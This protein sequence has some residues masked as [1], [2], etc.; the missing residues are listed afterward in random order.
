MNKPS[1]EPEDASIFEL[2]VSDDELLSYI[3]KPYHDSE[4][5][6]EKEFNLESV[7][8]KNMNLWLPEHWKNKD[9]YDYQEENLYQD[10]K[11]FTSVETIISVVNARI[12]TTDVMP[13]QDSDVSKQLAKDLSKTLF[14]HADK[15]RTI[16]LFRIAVRNLLIKR[17]GFVK[18]RYDAAIDDIVPEAIAPE[19]IIVDK[20]AVWGSVPRFIAQKIKNKTGEE[21]LSMFPGKEQ[22]IYEMF[23]VKRRD[24]KGN[25]VAYKAQMAKKKDILEVWFTYQEEGK[26]VSAVVFCDEDFRY[27]LDKMRNPN[28]NYEE[29]ENSLSNFL[30]YPMPPFIPVNYLNDGSSYIDLTSMVEQAAPLQM[31][32]DRRGFQ[33][34]E[35]ADQA[36]SG[37]VFNTQMIDKSDIA[38]LTGSPDERIGVMGSVRDAVARVAPPPL[39]SYV[40]EDKMDAR[41]AIDNIFATHEVT[42]GEKSGNRTLGQDR[43]QREQNYTRMDD[44][45]RA[46][47]RSVD[48]YNKYLV[49][50]MK[51]YYTEDHYFKAT[52]EDGQFDFLVMRSDMIED[53]ID[54]R[55]TAGSTLPIN[56]Q[57]Q[58]ENMESLVQLQMIDPLTVYEVLAGGN[59]PSP[60][61][62]LE[63]YMMFRT[64]PMTYMGQAKE[65]KFSR[66]AHADIQVLNRGVAPKLRSEYSETYLKTIN[67]HMLSGDFEKQPDLV[68]QLYIEFMRIVQMQVQ[69][70]LAG[71][72][73]QLPTE[74]DMQQTNQKAL[75]QAQ[76]EQQMGGGQMQGQ[77]G[78]VDQQ[79]QKVDQNVQQQRAK[80]MQQANQG[81]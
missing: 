81:A 75:E 62:I 14:A 42:R 9:I 25:L 13:A 38:K 69:K 8:K 39:P 72:M 48:H 60:N 73:T 79:A 34:M 43:M 15:H 10:P 28:W 37:L 26:W 17:I 47:E 56:R 46:V 50:M 76:I 21:L 3:R 52:G 7:R 61:K 22:T 29:E 24:S 51:V 20:D 2:K 31:I 77:A 16:D 66:E 78:K 27:V 49:Q 44:I 59:L 65:D 74:E 12:P 40:L 57:Q 33:I 5:Y 58:L 71:M 1:E 63:R 68:K 4:A 53:G 19:D 54:L 6:W 67:S 30:D 36:G 55:V 32:L 35:N 41:K 80:E 18:L 23:G 45:A 70:Q 64:D 11:I